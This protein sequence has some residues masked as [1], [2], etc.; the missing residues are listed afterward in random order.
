MDL[1]VHKLNSEKF[2]KSL[3]SKDLLYF[4]KLTVGNLLH[5]FSVEQ[6]NGGRFKK[7]HSPVKQVPW[8]PYLSYPHEKKERNRRII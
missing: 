1:V 3:I 7:I 4:Q 5:P 8:I 2:F 6:T